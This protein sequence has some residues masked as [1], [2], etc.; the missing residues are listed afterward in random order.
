MKKVISVLMTVA[1]LAALMVPAFALDQNT[2]KGDT[3]VKTGTTME[4]GQDARR[5]TVTIP[6]D[7]VI[8]WGAEKNRPHRLHRRST[9]RLRRKAFGYRCRQRQYDLFPGSGRYAGTALYA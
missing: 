4:G 3:I 6:A 9:P 8:T 2:P 1:M 7:T 5:Y